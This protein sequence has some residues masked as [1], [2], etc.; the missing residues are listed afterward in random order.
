[1][2]DKCAVAIGVDHVRSLQPLQGAAEGADKFGTWAKNQ[3]FDVTILTGVCKV[4]CVS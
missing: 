4:N 1:M 2:S 3:G